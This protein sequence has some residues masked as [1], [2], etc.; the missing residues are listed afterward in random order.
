MFPKD[1]GEILYVF[2]GLSLLKQI[3]FSAQILWANLK[4]ALN[5]EPTSALK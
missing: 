3:Q 4:D 2:S 5:I 1:K